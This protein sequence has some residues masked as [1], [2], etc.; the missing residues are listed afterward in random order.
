M[1]C[2]LY[3]ENGGLQ[4]EVHGAE[5]DFDMAT[6]SMFFG[7][8]IKMYKER[9]GKHHRPHIHAQHA[10][11]TASFDLETRDILAGEMDK[12]DVDRIK[13]WMSI[14]REELFANW[15]LLGEEGTYFKIE[16]LR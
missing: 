12:D 7:I 16:P 14:H 2:R 4:T 15:K 10:D 5:G 8:I 11:K 13:G 6:L 1:D 3:H 9:D